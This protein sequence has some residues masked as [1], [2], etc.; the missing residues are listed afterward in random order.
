VRRVQGVTLPPLD[1]GLLAGTFTKLVEAATL[2]DSAGDEL[3]ADGAVEL[4]ERVNFYLCED[5]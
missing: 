2:L 5:G 1:H 3:L 4:A